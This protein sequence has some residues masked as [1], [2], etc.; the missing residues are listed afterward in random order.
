MGSDAS[1]SVDLLCELAP[2]HAL[3]ALDPS[4][5]ASYEAHLAAC[6]ACVVE[7]DAYLRVAEDLALVSATPPPPALRERLLQSIAT[8]AETPAPPIQVWKDWASKDAPADAHSVVRSNAG[9]WEATGSA[10][11]MVRRLAVDLERQ[12]ATMLVKMEPGSSYP[13]HLHATA[14]ECFVLDGDLSV[15]DDLVM[16]AGDFQR[17]R[18]GTVHP[19]QSTSGGCTLFIISSLHDEL[20]A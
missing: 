19:I 16:Y 3:G 5:R 15:G 18:G 12:T 8:D 14:E 2:L 1:N 9:G 10:G 4:E 13:R 17:V 11:V 6:A 7:L 20:M